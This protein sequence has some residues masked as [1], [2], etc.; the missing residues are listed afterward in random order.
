M[1]L[2]SKAIFDEE[3]LCFGSQKVVYYEH[4]SKNVQIWKDFGVYS[5]NQSRSDKMIYDFYQ[6]HSN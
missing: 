3:K 2:A 6:Q 4:N 1:L 5:M